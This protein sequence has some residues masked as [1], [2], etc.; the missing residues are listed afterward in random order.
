VEKAKA[1]DAEGAEISRRSPREANADSCGRTNIR[2][3]RRAEATG[4]MVA[5]KL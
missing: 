4:V 5:G 1:L 2:K 3:K